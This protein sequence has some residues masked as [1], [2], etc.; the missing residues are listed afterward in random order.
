MENTEFLLRCGKLCPLAEMAAIKEIT[1]GNFIKAFA[2]IRQAIEDVPPLYAQEEEA[3]PIVYLHY[4]GGSH[5]FYITEY[6]E[7]AP[8]G[9]DNLAYGVT[10][11][12]GEHEYGYISINELKQIAVINLDL[13]FTPCRLSEIKND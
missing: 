6:S 9:C 11:V 4:F 1:N 2:N 13:H 12:Y 8:D 7:T 3:D 5:D 10:A